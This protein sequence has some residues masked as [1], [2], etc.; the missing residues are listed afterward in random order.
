MMQ[1]FAHSIS[2]DK[3][4]HLN[5]KALERWDVRQRAASYALSNKWYWRWTRFKKMSELFAI[6]KETFEEIIVANI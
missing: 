4:D 6:V 3:E 5:K 1:V 2:N